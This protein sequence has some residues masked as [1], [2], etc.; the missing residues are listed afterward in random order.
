MNAER[1]EVWCNCFLLRG[2]MSIMESAVLSKTLQEQSEIGRFPQAAVWQPSEFQE[3]YKSVA[4]RQMHILHLKDRK[5]R[6]GNPL[7]LGLFNQCIYILAL[8]LCLRRYFSVFQ[9]VSEVFSPYNTSHYAVVLLSTVWDFMILYS[10]MVTISVANV[11]STC[12][13]HTM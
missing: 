11:C 5:E 9:E 8:E 2:S 13:W 12:L 1:S 3:L 6:Y 7:C 10:G 4:W